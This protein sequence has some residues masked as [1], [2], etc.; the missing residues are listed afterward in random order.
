MITVHGTGRSH[1][2]TAGG[3]R[4]VVAEEEGRT[5]ARPASFDAEDYEARHAVERT[6]NALKNFRAVSTQFDDR[7]YV[8]YGT[9][10]VVSIRIWLRS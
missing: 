9:V 2:R 4:A 5:A 6:I 1:G 3:A 7:A 10:I 8:F